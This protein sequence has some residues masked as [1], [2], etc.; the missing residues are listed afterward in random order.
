MKKYNVLLCSLGYLPQ[1][2]G[3]VSYLKSFSRWVIE[4]GGSATIFTTDGKNGDLAEEESI[5]GVRVLR[6]RA[7]NFSSAFKILTPF[8]VARMIREQIKEN[9]DA[10]NSAD[11]IVIRHVYYA[12]AFLAFPQFLSKCIFVAPLISPKLQIINSV[13]KG[14]FYWV[15]SY[16]VAAQLYFMERKA[17]T[18]W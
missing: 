10:L 3:L 12:Y 15:Y 17:L 7:F 13:G 5:D 1:Y 18:G 4:S 11:I 16:F 6:K 2:G 14:F 8:L 9:N